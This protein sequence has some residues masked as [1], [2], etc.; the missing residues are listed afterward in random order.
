MMAYDRPKKKFQEKSE[1][2]NDLIIFSLS[3]IEVNFLIYFKFK[4]I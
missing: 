1:E 4:T 3:N 2:E